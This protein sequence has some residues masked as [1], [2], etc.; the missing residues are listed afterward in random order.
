MF[1]AAREDEERSL[2][3]KLATFL[4]W[5]NQGIAEASAISELL[6]YSSIQ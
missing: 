1:R 2:A 4:D 3:Q 5:V 6:S